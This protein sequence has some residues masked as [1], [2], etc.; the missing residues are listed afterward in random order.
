M[1]TYNTL[2]TCVLIIFVFLLLSMLSL[3]NILDNYLKR[4]NKNYIIT[5]LIVISV[6]LVVVSFLTPYFYTD[7]DI[8]NSISFTQK[9]GYTG[10]TLGGIMNPF[11]ALAGA[12][13]TFIAFY[14]QKIA[15]DDIKNQFKIQQFESQFYEM[16]HLHRENLNEMNIEGYVYEYNNN[17]KS[18]KAKKDSKKEKITSGKKVFVTM[19]KEFEAIHLIATKYFMFH[20]NNMTQPQQ[21]IIK[22]LLKQFIFDH[23][24]FVFFNGINFYKKNIDRYKQNDATGFLGLVL[25]G[26][27]KELES[28][29]K[30][31]EELGIKE[32]HQYYTTG[33]VLTHNFKTRSLRL[34]FNYKPFSG[35]QS[36][37]AHYYRH[38]FQTVKFVAKQKENLISYESKRDYL[39]VLR[40]MLSNHEQ[41][42]ILY[43]WYGGFGSNWEEKTISKR[44]NK[45]GNY[46]FTDYRMIHNIPP[47]LLISELNLREIFNSN[48]TN[49]LYEED[50]KEE[51]TLFELIEDIYS[52][53]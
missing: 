24:Y 8:G 47:D 51:D 36:I 10:D 26:F 20:L 49:F 41:V 34:S 28:K 14:I 37:L 6:I 4:V 23:S 38:L 45:R 33:S 30:S 44:K 48:F 32:H 5:P 35:H 11:I 40:S 52:S 46:F 7:T 9:T 18:K 15:N 17:D 3:K 13:L 16:L 1:S 39:R 2:L 12:V 50:R 22:P 29:R 43:N 42:L 21:E 19:L 53:K 31:H 25:D 27:V